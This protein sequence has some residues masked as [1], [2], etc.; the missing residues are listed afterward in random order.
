M[1]APSAFAAAVFSGPREVAM[2]RA[3]AALA[4]WMA[5]TPMPLVAPWISRVSP[6]FSA[7]ALEDI[8]EDGEDRL[9]QGRG[10]NEIET[11]RDRQ[12]VPGVDH[13]EFGIAAAAQQGAD[14]VAGL[15][16]GDALP[17]LI[18]LAGDLESQNVRRAGRRGIVGRGAA[19]DRAGSRR[20][21]D[22]DADLAGTGLRIGTF[23]RLQGLGRTGAA[24]DLDRPHSG[25]TLQSG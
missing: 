2:T 25:Q 18:H 6:A 11:L 23:A 21:P 13:R 7:A 15:P 17:D 9:R 16:A 4:I 8:G 20:R 22:P 1:S 3:P 5:V 10:L 19:A 12:G 14:P 24:G